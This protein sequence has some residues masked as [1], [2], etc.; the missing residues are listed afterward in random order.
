[1]A[2]GGL[3][4]TLGVESEVE[5]LELYENQPLFGDVCKFMNDNGFEFYDF[6]VEYRYGRKEL[7]RKGQLAFADALFLRTPEW[8]C[9][10]YLNKVIDEYKVWNYIKICT[11]YNKLDL[12]EVVKNKI[13]LK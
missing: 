5:F 6:V 11:V 4:T 7:N 2:V 9:E 13:N 1:M 8:V 12:I 3:E 10:N